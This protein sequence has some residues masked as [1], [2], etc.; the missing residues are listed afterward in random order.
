MR[1]ELIKYEL[2]KN[3]SYQDSDKGN[4]GYPECPLSPFRG[5][6]LFRSYWGNTCKFCPIFAFI[7]FNTIKILFFVIECPFSVEVRNDISTSFVKVRT[8]NTSMFRQYHNATSNS[9]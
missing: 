4:K 8:T 1:S 6:P 5:F 2:A 9:V 3:P 7:G